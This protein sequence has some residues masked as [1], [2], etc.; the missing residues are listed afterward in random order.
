MP[1]VQLT[2]SRSPTGLE[3][4]NSQRV[5]RSS[6]TSA[7]FPVDF[8][9]IASLVDTATSYTDT[10]VATGDYKYAIT[11][12]S[13]GGESG[14]TTTTVSVPVFTSL[15][16][17]GSDADAG[18]SVA[19]VR[20]RALA[21]QVDY[22]ADVGGAVSVDRQL[23]VVVTGRDG[24]S[25]VFATNQV[26]FQSTPFD[27]IGVLGAVGVNEPAIGASEVTQPV[28]G[29]ANVNQSATGR[30]DIEESVAG[31]SDVEESVAGTAD[32]RES[33]VGDTDNSEG[34]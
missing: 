24:D 20:S 15:S 32:V 29:T 31:V 13:S 8:T 1:D 27:V 33:V 11:A 4:V 30:I 2:W 17:D 14:A 21:L 28:I 25:S 18:G 12:V 22:D 26:P 3:E 6:D 10:G 7:S 23:F 34:S 16:L 9:Q 19:I 5:Y